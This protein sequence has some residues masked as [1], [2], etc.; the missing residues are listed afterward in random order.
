[1]FKTTVGISLIT[2]QE[3]VFVEPGG[4]APITDEE[5]VECL[6]IGREERLAAERATLHRVIYPNR[7]RQQ[8][9]TI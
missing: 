6:R 5:I 1:M 3:V 2:G 9:P 8:Q 7:R 4:L